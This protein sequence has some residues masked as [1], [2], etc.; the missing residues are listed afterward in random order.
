M[1]EKGTEA[2]TEAKTYFVYEKVVYVDAVVSLIHVVYAILSGNNF[3]WFMLLGVRVPRIG[4]HLMAK[5]E[6]S[7]E[8]QGR[9][10]LFR[11]FSTFGYMP[12]AWLIVTLLGG[13]LFT[14]S[15]RNTFWKDPG[16]YWPYAIWMLILLGLH[17]VLDFY[18][19]LK[20]VMPELDPIMPEFLK[21]SKESKEVQK[22]SSPNARPIDLELE[23][24]THQKLASE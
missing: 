5:N 23:G 19:W 2:V 22:N 13:S 15:K 9:E 24:P 4:L 20:V 7:V 17:T 12:V 16:C 10:Y 21:K 18:I 14:C 6:K 11:K 8:W 3:S 1:K